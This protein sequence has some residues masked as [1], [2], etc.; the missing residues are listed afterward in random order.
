MADPT[1]GFCIENESF[2]HLFFDCIVAVNTW[3]INDDILDIPMPC[4]FDDIVVRWNKK[5][6]DVVVNMIT[7]TTFCSLWL[8]P[9]EFIFQ[10]HTW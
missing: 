1:C 2:E 9:N 3:K 5:N 6:R 10:G 8:L 4:S 7:S